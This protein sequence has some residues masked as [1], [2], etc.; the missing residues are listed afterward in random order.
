MDLSI[1]P[2]Q[3]TTFPA[4]R[5]L[6]VQLTEH[7]REIYRDPTIGGD[8]PGLG[9]EEYLRNPD[10]KGPWVAELDGDVVGFTGLLVHGEEAEIEPLIVASR[11]RGHGIGTA[12]LDHA[13]Q[14]AKS[15]GVRF[16]SVRPVARNSRAIELFVRAGF[17]LVGHVDLFKDLSESSERHWKSTIELHGMKLRY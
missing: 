8:D 13:T 1:R 14:R 3:Q 17:D 9:F 11:C 16:L 6:W 15:F 10:L 5:N 7:H 4:C 2:Y 12:L